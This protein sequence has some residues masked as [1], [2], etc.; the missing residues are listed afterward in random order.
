[1]KHAVLLF[2]PLYAYLQIQHTQVSALEIR[3]FS[4]SSS[5]VLISPF[6]F[7]YSLV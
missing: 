5:A 6:Y 4:L 3:V 1:M 7:V 2:S